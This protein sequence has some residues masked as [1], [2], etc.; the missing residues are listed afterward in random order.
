MFSSPILLFDMISAKATI[1]SQC[2]E[3]FYQENET[4]FV[5]KPKHAFSYL[6]S[7]VYNPLLSACLQSVVFRFY[8]SGFLNT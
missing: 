7:L 8:K 1:A 2:M 5:W 4:I 3:L 6:F